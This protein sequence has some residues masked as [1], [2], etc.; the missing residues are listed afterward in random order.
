MQEERALERPRPRWMEYMKMEFGETDC[1]GM[2]WIGLAQDRHRWNALVNAAMNPLF[3]KNARKLSSGC[4]IDD[5]WRSAQ[6]H[7][8]S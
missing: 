5:L 1:G 4:T 3:P 7:T 2:D 6:L 8:V